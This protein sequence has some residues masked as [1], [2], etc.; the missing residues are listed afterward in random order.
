MAGAV[1]QSSSCLSVVPV[2][3]NGLSCLASE[4]EDVPSPAETGSATGWRV[5]WGERIGRGGFFL[6]EGEGGGGISRESHEG[7]SEDQV[8]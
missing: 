3:L 8:S 2:P 4:G 6:G 7:H 1:F 5:V